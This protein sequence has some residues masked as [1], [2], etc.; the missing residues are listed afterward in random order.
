[1]GTKDTK[2]PRARGN[3]LAWGAVNKL[4]HASLPNPSGKVSFAKKHES[5]RS[6]IGETFVDFLVATGA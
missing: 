4:P 5:K 3:L 2:R 6:A 1:M